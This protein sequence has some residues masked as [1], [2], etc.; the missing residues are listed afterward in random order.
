MGYKATSNH[1][2]WPEPYYNRGGDEHSDLDTRRD[3]R[4][5]SG[6]RSHH[7]P[8]PDLRSRL[9]LGGLAILILVAPLFTGGLDPLP[10]LL[11]EWLGLGLIGLV[12]WRP[13]PGRFSAAELVLLGAI[14]LI[15]L[16]YLIPWPVWMDAYLP[17]REPDQ[18][19]I[20]TVT[21]QGLG[22]AHPLSLHPFA[23]E[24]AWLTTLI[25]LGVYL[26]TRSLGENRAMQLV[27][28]LFA[29][30]LVQVLIAIFQFASA[31]S[32]VAYGPA[33]LVPRGGFAAGTYSNR[34]HLAGM[35]EMVFPLALALFLYHFGRTPYHD[36]TPRGW[37][38][39]VIATLQAG[40]RPSLAFVLLAILFVVGIV[41]TRSRSGIALAMLGLCL[42]VILFTRN[43]GG[44]T[45]LGLVGR[46]SILAIGF[47][48]ALGLAPVL[49]RFATSDMA[50][51]ARWPLAT[52]TFHG[53]G[54][55]LPL[56]SGPGTYPDAFPV[57]QPIELGHYF[58]NHAHN[59]YL[60]ALYEIGIWAPL[61]LLAFLGLYARQWSR[62]TTPDEWSIYRCL[63]VGAGVGLF[64][65]LGHS[66]TDYN[67]HTPANLAYF[68]LLAG[69][70]FDPPGRLPVSH[71][72]PR[73]ERRTRTMREPTG[74]PTAPDPGITEP[75]APGQR[76][77]NPFDP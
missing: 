21:G 17:G 35:L 62:L 34:N 8:S 50:A 73:R 23:T 13:E 25:P 22:A 41:A 58:I 71:H 11:L 72:R 53:A 40:G 9:V 76:A 59:D 49:D 74:A 15:P 36:R 69:L 56:G 39:K 28:L 48:G 42:T 26:G 52:A 65:I 46:L 44:R 33:E 54:R 37:R 61:L 20:V 12:L 14:F 57:D 5:T 31:T 68:A 2:N 29:V 67:L 47:A 16:L 6:T 43:L 24:S 51:D 70:F 30:A 19:A 3:D 64:L 1:A 27:Y 55:R 38:K 75:P 7:D 45:A 66:L 4:L 18:N 77:R 32:G 60:E 63:Q 10:R